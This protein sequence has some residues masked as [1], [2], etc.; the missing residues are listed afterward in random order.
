ME[1]SKTISPNSGRIDRSTMF[2]FLAAWLGWGFD[3]LDGYLYSMVSIRFV[4]ELMHGASK[5]HIGETA[6]LIQA[7]FLVG[8]ACGGV[9]FGRLGDLLGRAR[10]LTFTILLYAFCTGAAFFA[11][12]WWHLLILRFVAALGIGGEWAAGSALVA[13]TLPKKY[14]YWASAI[15]QNGY[16]C[17]M[18]GAALT[19]GALGQFSP[20]YVFLIG[21]LPAF[22]TLWIRRHVPESSHW[23]AQS[24][25][26]RPKLADLFKG[27]VL[28]TTLMTLALAGIALTSVWAF[29]FFNSQ[30]IA[31][32]PSVK[33]LS[34]AAQAATVRSVTV[35]FCLWNIAGNFFAAGIARVVGYRLAFALLFASSFLCY[36]FGFR[37]TGDLSST[38]NWL[39]ATAFFSSGVF[40]LFP[41]YIPPL[42]PTL[43]RT[44]GAGLTYNFGRLTAA[45]GTLYGG[46]LA[47][48]A[49]GPHLAIYFAG[50]LYLPGILIA[51]LAPAHRP[52]PQ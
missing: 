18:I 10:T 28:P 11:Q 15:L 30:V 16:I 1:P 36:F 21:V 31:Q 7:V 29:L 25:Q 22:F 40:A 27:S 13:E 12:T 48:S 3:G 9:L 45:A 6:A 4:T 41:L 38:T 32:I 35:I 26:D 44:T 8:W 20:R 19:V 34:P 47:T 42:F 46:V 39:S 37:S 43:L 52:E 33:A 49:G 51:L 50:F 5:V 17:G 23:E 2:A 24:K 14:S